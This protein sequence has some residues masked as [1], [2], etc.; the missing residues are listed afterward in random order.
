MAVEAKSLVPDNARLIG[1]GRV[2]ICH[3]HLEHALKLSLKRLLEISLDDPDYH[4]KVGK[5]LASKLRTRIRNQLLVKFGGGLGVLPS[6]TQMIEQL[7]D[8]AEKLTTDRNR[9]THGN[10]VET[11]AGERIIRDR[12]PKTSQL[13]TYPIPSAEALNDLGERCAAMA[14][15]FD[16]ITTAWLKR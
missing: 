1:L 4:D 11:E 9:Y 14:L 10:W 7:L 3:G 2:T 12:D 8:D 15:T 13:K 5:L 16:R 6:K